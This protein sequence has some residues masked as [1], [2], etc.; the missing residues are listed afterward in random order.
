MGFV[1]QGCFELTGYYP[2]DLTGQTGIPY[3]Q[4][5]HPA[6]RESTWQVVQA[7]LAV[8]R[9]FRHV[10]RLITAT[11]EEK[12][13]WEQGRGVFGPDDKL[14][15]LEGFITDVTKSKQAEA[16]LYQRNRELA[17]LNKIIAVSAA[18]RRRQPSWK[19]PA[20]N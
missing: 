9:P 10:Y 13:V 19:L 14:L 16:Q 7:A 3:N 15:F 6:D 1:S 5:I 4:L 8:R 17:M 18:G 11:G 20:W 12:W 2:A